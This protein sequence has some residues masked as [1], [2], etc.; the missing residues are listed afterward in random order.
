MLAK[1]ANQNC[2]LRTLVLALKCGLAFNLA[3][4][5]HVK[6]LLL[7]VLLNI[8]LVFVHQH[9]QDVRVLFP[10]FLLDGLLVLLVL[11]LLLLFLQGLAFHDL[12][13]IKAQILE[14]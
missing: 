3:F 6:R 4:G 14:S 1:G 5:L 10:Y 12:L 7:R 9:L 8:L 2:Y 13:H 11:L